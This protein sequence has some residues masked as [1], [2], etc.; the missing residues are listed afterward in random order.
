MRKQTLEL[1]DKRDAIAEEQRIMFEELIVDS[2]NPQRT[3]YL[4]TQVV[5]NAVRC[6]QCNRTIDAAIERSKRTFWDT[7]YRRLY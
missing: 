1:F 6:E 5:D 7:F 2:V 3:A 4:L